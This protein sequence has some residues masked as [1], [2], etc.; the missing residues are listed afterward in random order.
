[1]SFNEEKAI[2]EERIQINRQKT[3]ADYRLKNGDKLIHKTTRLEPPVYRSEPT[4]I[5]EDEEFFVIDKP[6]SIPVHECGSYFHNSLVRYLQYVRG[7]PTLLP[8]H[9]LD[10]LTSGVLVL[11]K[12]SQ[13]AV[14]VNRSI[15]GG[16][17]EK[18]YLTRVEGDMESIVLEAK[19]KCLSRDTFKWGV[20]SEDD[21]EGK[22]SMTAFERLVY[23]SSD[24][25]TL[26]RCRLHSGRTHQIRVHLQHLGHPILNDVDYGGRWVGN[27]YG[28]YVLFHSEE[29]EEGCNLLI[30]RA[31]PETKVENLEATTLDGEESSCREKCKEIFL[32]SKSYSIGENR[33]ESPDPYWASPF[34]LF[35]ALPQLPKTV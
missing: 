35:P 18:I 24:N 23:F 20:C 8:P 22:P 4:L 3:T 31:D 26:M 21:P 30:K 15:E 16:A 34:L 9:R 7:G 11:A 5:H 12:N 10:R 6:P 27:L 32:H 33:F 2:A 19:M 13:A 1:M 25:T 14:K 28:K 29:A 17:A